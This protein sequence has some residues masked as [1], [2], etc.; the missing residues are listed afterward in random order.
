MVGKS[1]DG[2]FGQL[3]AEV[4][5]RYLPNT[6]I[7][8]LDDSRDQRQG[9]FGPEAQ[10]LALFQGKQSID[11]RATAYVCESFACRR[12]VT[13]VDDLSEQLDRLAGIHA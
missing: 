7:G 6:L 12:P 11:G 13:E 2:A 3:R 5:R 1:E 9:E 4:W 8:M 10:P